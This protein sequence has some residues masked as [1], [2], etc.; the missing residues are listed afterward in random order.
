MAPK[1]KVV[2]ESWLQM[3]LRVGL[4]ND[5]YAIYL[6]VYAILICVCHILDYGDLGRGS[7][8]FTMIEC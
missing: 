4:G 1:K 5:V 7:H 2:H 8:L 3:Q 6:Y